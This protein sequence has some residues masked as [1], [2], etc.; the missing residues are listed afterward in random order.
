M[1]WS[2]ENCSRNPEAFLMDSFYIFII[3]H[4][5]S[6]NKSFLSCIEKSSR[7]LKNLK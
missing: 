1:N 5:I 2:K 4:I 7:A 3:I 6:R